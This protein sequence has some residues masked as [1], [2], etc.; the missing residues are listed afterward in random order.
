MTVAEQTKDLGPWISKFT[1]DGVDTGGWFDV[2][3][4]GRATRWLDAI[5][6]PVSVLECGSLEGGHTALIARHPNVINV[7][8]LEGREANLR[9][10]RFI[11]QQLGITNS[12][13]DQCDLDTEPMDQFG[14]FDATFCS[15][16]LYHLMRPVEFFRRINSP[17]VFLGTHYSLEN[18]TTHEG[19]QGRWYAE[20]GLADVLSG[21][22]E[23]SFWLTLPNIE[24]MIADCG[25]SITSLETRE[26]P[27][28]P[29]VDVMAWKKQG[30]E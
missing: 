30:T 1:I 12:R 13:F 27:N 19:M 29:W 4:D 18:E 9:K 17:D 8:G 20:H 5:D 21:L 25:Y 2:L 14:Q 26:A 24:R 15:G 10:C 6:G 7:L 3:N 28:G 16:V 23:K 11:H 22:S